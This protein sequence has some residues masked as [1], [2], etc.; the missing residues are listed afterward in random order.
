MAYVAIIKIIFAVSGETQ[1]MTSTREFASVLFVDKSMVIPRVSTQRRNA[2]KSLS[3][4]SGWFRNN[5]LKGKCWCIFLATA[6]F[7]KIIHSATILFTGKSV[8]V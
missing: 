7:A 2:S 1:L 5:E 8:L 6:T 3:R 4:G